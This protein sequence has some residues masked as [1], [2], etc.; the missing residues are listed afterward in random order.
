MLQAVPAPKVKLTQ[1]GGKGLRPTVPDLYTWVAERPGERGSVI[2]ALE[3]RGYEITQNPEDPETIGFISPDG[4]IVGLNEV[5]DL[6]DTEA[7][8]ARHERVEASRAYQVADDNVAN[9]FEVDGELKP[10]FRDQIQEANRVRDMA[11]EELDV[12]EVNLRNANE[13]SMQLQRFMGEWQSTVTGAAQTDG[14]KFESFT[15]K[16]PQENYRELLIQLDRPSG[17]DSRKAYVNPAHFQ[18]PDILVHARVDDRVGPNGEKI[19]YVEEIQS[20]WHQDARKIRLAQA[21]ENVKKG[22]V[23]DAIADA[24]RLQV[25]RELGLPEDISIP[26]G[27]DNLKVRQRFKEVFGEI[28][29]AKIKEEAAKLPKDFGYKQMGTRVAPFS[30]TSHELAVKQLLDTAANEGYDK[31]MFSP[32]SEQVKRYSLGEYFDELQVNSMETGEGTMYNL[33]GFSKDGKKIDRTFNKKDLIEH[34]GEDKAEL[35]IDR[36]EE[37]R[38][39]GSR[40][41]ALLTGKDLL[42]GGKKAQGKLKIYDEII[43]GFVGKYAGKEFDVQPGKTTIDIED[44]PADVRRKN[45]ADQFRKK[46][47]QEL[48]DAL[49]AGNL[50]D[51]FDIALQGTLMERAREEVINEFTRNYSPL[52]GRFAKEFAPRVESRPGI[53][54]VNYRGLLDELD[55]ASYG[56]DIT[57]ERGR[58][59][60][61]NPQ[62]IFDL[63][64]PR[65]IKFRDPAKQESFQEWLDEAVIDYSG[66]PFIVKSVARPYFLETAE[67]EMKALGEDFYKDMPAPQR[68]EGTSIDITPEIREKLQTR[69]QP[70][71]VVPPAAAGAAAVLSEEEE[72]VQEFK[73]AGRVKKKEGM[74]KKQ[75]DSPFDETRRIG[76]APGLGTKPASIRSLTKILRGEETEAK[77][78]ERQRIAGNLAAGR[79]LGEYMYDMIVPQTPWEVALEAAF[80]PIPRPLRKAALAVAG[81]MYDPEAE[82]GRLRLLHGS[83][84]KLDRLEEGRELYMTTDPEYAL[85]RGFDKMRLA[86]GAQG[87]AMVNQFGMEDTELMRLTDKYSAEDIDIARRA[88]SNLPQGREVTGEEIY[89]IASRNTGGGKKAALENTARALGKKGYQVQPG[90]DDK[91]DWYR[92]LD[93]TDLEPYG[94][95][96]AIK[97]ASEAISNAAKSAGAKSA[98]LTAEKELTTIEDTY[99]SLADRVKERVGEANRMIENFSY[100]YE[101]GQYVFTERG[102]AKN[103]SPLQI[104][105]RVRAGNNPVY[106]VPGDLGSGRVIDPETG[107]TKRT[108][109]EPGYVVRQ[110]FDDGYNEF[111]IPESAIRGKVDLEP[112]GKGGAIKSASEAISNAAKSAAQD[113]AFDSVNRQL[114]DLLE[115]YKEG[116]EGITEKDLLPFFPGYNEYDIAQ[117]YGT[118]TESSVP[119][120]SSK[121]RSFTPEIMSNLRKYDELMQKDFDRLVKEK[122]LPRDVITARTLGLAKGGIV[123]AIKSAMKMTDEVPDPSRR[124]A[125]GLREKIIEPGSLT[126]IEK[127]VSASDLDTLQKAMGNVGQAILNE[128]V[129]RREVLKRGALST[130]SNLIPG[131]GALTQIAK[132]MVPKMLDVTEPALSSKTKVGITPT[133]QGAIARA[134]REGLE[135][136]EIVEQL[137]EEF[138]QDTIDADELIDFVIPAMRDPYGAV[139]FGSQVTAMGPLEYLNRSLGYPGS[140]ELRPILR[141]IKDTDFL[142]YNQLKDAARQSEEMIAKRTP[143]TTYE[144]RLKDAE[145]MAKKGGYPF[146]MEKF[147]ER[148]GYPKDFDPNAP[149]KRKKKAD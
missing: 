9:M 97:S 102:A 5:E 114:S 14:P 82:A 61:A 83:P 44:V 37:N 143:G 38:A 28:E 2:D 147:R 90:A 67:K 127:E 109:Y 58:Y 111:I 130:A 126:T 6:L 53:F 56:A 115:R 35:A 8:M 34:I 50:P 45:F 13:T 135:E 99:T 46:R 139:D 134:L 136:E 68:L 10:E 60:R 59:V 36:I 87:P 24:A 92:V 113:K 77:N 72:P 75:F 137:L 84:S 23:Q 51:E 76:K 138:P 33:S 62:E 122:R 18:E 20:D 27:I 95:G 128:P 52:R 110:K 69:G 49:E 146:N 48:E 125:I 142:L 66:D 15:T 64:D 105:A 41:P 63:L 132:E 25:R 116:N 106:K 103:L 78:L 124:K 65:T 26:H 11:L 107:K 86:R 141:E 31:V 91:G 47:V 16:G 30:Q 1:R 81:G 117:M 98:P 123:D 42:L 71:F 96:G 39:A 19:L 120:M 74:A 140:N 144:R 80:F 21:K 32:G 85:K 129:S 70:L 57:P 73:E 55:P 12:Y 79:G 100:S 29:D 121:A 17:Q 133:I 93:Q 22:S 118:T 145:A 3:R 112:Y 101:P 104:I 148:Y 7:E 89:E 108:P 4:D 131:G 54:R 40:A 94:K 149:K 43:P 88:F 119:S